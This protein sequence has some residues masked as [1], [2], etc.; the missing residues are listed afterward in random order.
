[1]NEVLRRQLDSLVKNIESRRQIEKLTALLIL[2]VGLAFAYL[3]IVF[4]PM[5]ADIN[6]SRASIVGLDRQIQAQQVTYAGMLEASQ[7]DP[8]RFANDRV[9]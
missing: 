4:D 3:S 2:V 6:S 8:N 1:M 9:R 7:E 5:R